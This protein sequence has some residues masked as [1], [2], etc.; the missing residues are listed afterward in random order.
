MVLQNITISNQCHTYAGAY[1]A[2]R[3]RV[4]ALAGAVKIPDEALRLPTMCPFLPRTSL[5]YQHRAT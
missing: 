2:D 5:Q 3:K 4:E 1:T